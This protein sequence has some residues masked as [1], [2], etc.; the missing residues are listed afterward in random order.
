MLWWLVIDPDYRNKWLWNLL[1]DQ[2]FEYWKNEKE[3]LLTYTLNPLVAKKRESQWFKNWNKTKE[4]VPFNEYTKPAIEAFQLKWK[5]LSKSWKTFS[6]ETPFTNKKIFLEKVVPL[7]YKTQNLTKEEKK[8]IDKI[9][10][11]EYIKKEE[12]YNNI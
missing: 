5:E 7:S 12:Y 2:T 6:E 8:K 10:N 3:L 4:S 9:L 11:T 1:L